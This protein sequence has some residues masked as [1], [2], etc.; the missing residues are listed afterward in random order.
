MRIVCK[1]YE[2]NPI[3]TKDDIPYPCDAVYNAGAAKYNGKYILLLRTLL[4]NG[5][6]VFG[7]AESDDGCDFIVKPKPVMVPAD[8]GPFK[9]YEE[10]GI[11]DPRITRIGDI[12]YI[13]Y[14]AYSRYGMR[15]GLAMTKDFKKFERIALTTTV[16][17][18]NSVLFPKKI[19]GKFCRFERPNMGYA[20]GIWISYSRDLIHW[21]E[22]E[23]IMTPYGN[24]IWEDHK[25]GPGA[26]PIETPKGWLSIY[27]GVTWTMDGMTYRLGCALHD[28]NNPAKIIG[29][30]DQ[31]ILGPDEIYERVGYVH[32]VIFTCG[33][34]S[35][36]DGTVKIYYGGADQ[37]L[38]LATAK[39][40]D[41]IDICL[42]GKR[43]PL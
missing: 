8:K 10:K 4:L 28:L 26:P 43:P 37:C 17:Y 6:S 11:E 13:F 29:I 9:M 42:K 30:A 19:N 16:D 39:I 14:S 21:G 12:Y 2:K 18:R 35:E 32:N 31:F 20:M 34:I 3:L 15:I 36:P 38:C 40:A 1:K 7:L 24:H 33:A 22:Q 41:L 25:I 23:L 27:H 5:N